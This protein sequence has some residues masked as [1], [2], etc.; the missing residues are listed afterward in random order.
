MRPPYRSAA[1][2]EDIA[3]IAPGWRAGQSAA[4][5]G[6]AMEVHKPKPVHSWRELLGEIGVIVIGVIIALTAEQVV[7][8]IHWNHKVADAE[9][10]MNR[11]LGDDLAYAAG[12]LA[13]KDC[14]GKYFARIE[15]AVVNRR[16]DTLRQLAAMTEPP[17]GPHP[18]VG[19]SWTA[20]INS[21]I[22]DHIPRDRLSAYAIAFRRVTTERELQ[23]TMLDHYA[24]VVGARLLDSP[25]PE[26]SYAQLAA[27]D[28]LKAA[29]AVTRL[30]A[31]SL[32]N[33]Q[34]KQ[35]DA[36]PDPQVLAY[37]TR[38]AAVCEK[39]LAAITP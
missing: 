27:L 37:E 24:E 19:E 21:Q 30:I 32:I 4:L 31:Y 10:A 8:T 14:A 36:A 13:L 28:K 38:R 23:F 20:A 33:E 34:A 17:F 35:V 6:V 2:G 15:A 9:A 18:W 22:P 7:E 29:D 1:F 5:T 11:E 12:Q 26:I 25:T 39:Q 16:S 3:I